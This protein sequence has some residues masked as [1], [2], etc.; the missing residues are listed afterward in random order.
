M[1]KAEQPKLSPEEQAA[2]D[3]DCDIAKRHHAWIWVWHG[4]EWSIY[5]CCSTCGKIEEVTND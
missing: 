4:M 2:N 1:I 3:K 5:R